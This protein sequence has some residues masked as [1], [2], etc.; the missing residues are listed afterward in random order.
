MKCQIL[1]SRKIKKNISKC[2]L[3][4]F[5][6]SMQ[7]VKM[8]VTSAADDILFFFFFSRKLD[9]TFYVKHGLHAVS[10]DKRMCTSTG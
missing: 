3:L 8:P 1:F 2:C 7:S 4:K 6:P 10:Q 9:L 5:L